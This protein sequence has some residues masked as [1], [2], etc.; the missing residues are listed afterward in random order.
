MGCGILH[1]YMRLGRDL[2]TRPRYLHL[3]YQLT[4]KQWM[5]SD[6][7]LTSVNLLLVS[8]SVVFSEVLQCRSES[9]KVVL[10]FAEGRISLRDSRVLSLSG[11]SG[12]FSVPAGCPAGLQQYD[13]STYTAR[14]ELTYTVKRS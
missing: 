4:S 7:V 2:D 14:K 5:Q 8:C 13:I 11:S 3:R 1:R 9:W 12:H 10:T 6:M